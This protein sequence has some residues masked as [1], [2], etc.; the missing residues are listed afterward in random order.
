MNVLFRSDF[1]RT[2][3]K[4]EELCTVASDHA[5]I[6]W[7]TPE[8]KTDTSI[9]L[10][11]EKEN[12][13]RLTLK[14]AEEFHRAELN[15]LRPSTRYWY[16]VESNGARGAL[17]S[18]QTLPGPQGKHLFSCALFSDTHLAL[19]DSVRD[20]N[21]I[22]FGKLPEHS[23]ELF[24]QCIRDS[25]RR[26]IDLAV[27]TGDLTDASR[28]R[29]FKQ[30]RHQVLPAFGRVPYY[31]CIGNHDKYVERSGR[32]LGEK[33]FLQYVAGRENTYTNIDYQGYRFLLLDSCLKDND[34]GTIDEVQ[35]EWLSG[36]LSESGDRPCFLF[37]HHPCNGP[38]TWF[39]INNARKLR[40]ILRAFPNVRGVF[41]G[42]MHRSKVTANRLRTGYLPYVELPATVQFPCAYAVMRVYEKGFE[43]NVYKVSRLDLAEKSREKVI[44]KSLGSALY[45][46]Y[47]FGGIGD[48]SVSYFNGL[49]H[50][51]VQYELS[52]TL[53]DSR[54]VEL[55]ARA[56]SWEGASLAPAAEGG[57]LKVVLG[58]FDS[59]GAAIQA[60]QQRAFRY[61][62]KALVSKE[63]NYDVPAEIKRKAPN[64]RNRQRP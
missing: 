58:R 61:G 10:G 43:Y 31:L 7:V 32:G 14:R 42:H 9:Y 64:T 38:D 22:Y 44:L 47:A 13:T 52:V 30:A 20:P 50:R 24:S 60:Q 26:G 46:W 18:F 16:R 34:W 51:P 56:Q 63:G 59:R 49:L 48:R 17:S 55:Y 25:R 27:I 4:N 28:Q 36:T 62:I 45:T 1:S 15:N 57:K 3:I 5:V 53:E 19:G 39:G 6:T 54:A 2:L 8:Q 41:S 11:E 29:Q 37:L 12:L 35:L 33:G 21:E 40:Y 23:G